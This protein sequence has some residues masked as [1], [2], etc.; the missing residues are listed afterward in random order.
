M[1]RVTI[2]VDDDNIIGVKETLAMALEKHGDVKVVDISTRNYHGRG[3]DTIGDRIRKARMGEC[4]TQ[5]ELGERIHVS[6][7]TV[8]FWETNR[9]T[10]TEAYLLDI[11]K[12]CQVRPGWL[13]CKPGEVRR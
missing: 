1:I 6:E 13:L 2:D 3:P 11:A 9:R 10:P 8:A 7:S 5:R 4:M 12:I